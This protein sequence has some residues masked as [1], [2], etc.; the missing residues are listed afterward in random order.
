[1]N[2]NST[3]RTG[4]AT[5]KKFN[6]KKI[7]REEI[8]VK[9][10]GSNYLEIYEKMKIGKKYGFHLIKIPLTMLLLTIGLFILSVKINLGLMGL[11]IFGIACLYFSFRLAFMTLTLKSLRFF[12]DSLKDLLTLAYLEKSNDLSWSDF[13]AQFIENWNAHLV[14]QKISSHAK[15]VG[16][17]IS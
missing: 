14:K 16:K 8:Y 2:E 17:E 5:E 1:M 15:Q 4:N 10:S 6:P 12:N 13:N 11:A 9:I 3:S 7:L